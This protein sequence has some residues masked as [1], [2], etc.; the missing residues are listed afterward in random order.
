MVLSELVNFL[1]ALPV[2]FVMLFLA[3][4]PLTVFIAWLPLIIA[5]QLVLHPGHGLP[6]GHGQRLLPG[7]GVIME[8]VLLA[9]FFLSP[10][11]YSYDQLTDHGSFARRCWTSGRAGS[12]TILNP[13]AS[14]MSSYRDVL[15]GSP[16]GPPAAPELDFLLR[17]AVTSL[18]VLAFGYW[19]F[20]RQAGR[21]GE[22]V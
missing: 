8:V 1:L 17:T 14:L 2:L 3:G 15:F 9:W 22:E 20:V 10:I 11:F 12:C 16:T 19:V 7:H 18:V 6:A 13:L 5:I 4:V 21:F